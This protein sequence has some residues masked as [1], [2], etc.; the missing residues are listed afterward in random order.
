MKNKVNYKMVVLGSAACLI[1]C[2]IGLILWNKLPEAVAFHWNATGEVDRYA[3]KAVVAFVMPVCM[4]AFNALLHFLSSFEKRRENYSK[5]L[6]SMLYWFIPVLTLVI[7]S[8][9]YA[10]ALGKKVN[11]EVVLP[12]LIGVMLIFI[13][14]YLPKCK[15][16]STMG[17]KLPWTL[18]S[19]ENWN[20]THHMAGFLWIVCGVA[21]TASAFLQNIYVMLAIVFVSV[22]ATTVYSFVLH[23]KGI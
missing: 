2:L 6:T 14:N 8:L 9:S 19:E 1:P 16:N 7:S 22:I 18:K 23:K 13:G 5:A 20:R 21:V 15:Q 11:V 17:I 10:V 4:A 12:T 3:S